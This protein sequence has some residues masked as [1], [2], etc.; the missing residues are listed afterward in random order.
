MLLK[1]REIPDSSPQNY[2]P[3]QLATET[4]DDQDDDFSTE[5]NSEADSGMNPDRHE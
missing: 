3:I 5:P 2:P 4:W 1:L